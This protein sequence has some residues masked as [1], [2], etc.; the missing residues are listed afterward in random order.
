MGRYISEITVKSFTES[1]VS[2]GP[3]ENQI[4]DMELIVMIQQGESKVEIDMS[5]KYII[6]FQGY[7]NI[8]FKDIDSA[9][10]LQIIECLCLY[11]SVYNVI[12]LFFGKT[13]ENKGDHYLKYIADLYQD[14]HQPLQR[15]RNTGVFDLPPLPGLMLNANSAYSSPLLPAPVPA[16]LGNSVNTFEY[17]NKHLNN[18]SQSLL[19]GPYNGRYP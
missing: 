9:T 12:K 10:T 15:K 4:S 13:G 5:N 7:N 3:G 18:P 2:Y 19:W 1:K 16:R 14:L 6:P 11:R 8:P 17:A